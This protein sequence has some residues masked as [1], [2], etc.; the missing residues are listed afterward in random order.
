MDMF[1]GQAETVWNGE[2]QGDSWEINIFQLSSILPY[3]SAANGELATVFQPLLINVYV[4]EWK[5]N[6]IQL[7]AYRVYGERVMKANNN[8]IPNC[9]KYFSEHLRNQKY[10]AFDFYTTLMN[11]FK[12]NDNYMYHLL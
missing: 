5:T 8:F 9:K 4:V 10:N 12:H 11:P 3:F 7:N 1:T 2:C 6:I